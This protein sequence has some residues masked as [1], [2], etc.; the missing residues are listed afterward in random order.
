MRPGIPVLRTSWLIPV[1]VGLDAVATRTF[2]T[3][4]SADSTGNRSSPVT[5]N[6]AGSSLLFPYLEV[7]APQYNRACSNVTLNTAAGG[8]GLGISEAAAGLLQ[9]GGS[10]PC[11]SST[12]AILSSV[13][14]VA[15][16]TVV[17][18]NVE[19]AINKITG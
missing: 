12:A 14:F 17:V 18:P 3:A 15:L 2:G 19:A 5:L 13:N 8:S 11:L 16:P 1:V 4:V 6:E 7:L 10:E 9:M